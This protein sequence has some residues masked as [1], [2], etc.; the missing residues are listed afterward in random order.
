M[1]GLSWWQW[2]MAGLL[3]GGGVVYLVAISWIQLYRR[4]ALPW[5]PNRIR[6]PD[7][8][9]LGP[10]KLLSRESY[11]PEAERWLLI[12]RLAL[13]IGALSGFVLIATL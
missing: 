5:K 10:L 4:D 13:A 11:T 6:L 1:R 7:P 2:M 3:T 8:L 12:A 9:D